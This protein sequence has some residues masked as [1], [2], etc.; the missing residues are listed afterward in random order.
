MNYNFRAH[1]QAVVDKC[2]KQYGTKEDAIFVLDAIVADLRMQV[3]G[4]DEIIQDLSKHQDGEIT[5]DN[6]TKTKTG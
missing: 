1:K 2:T 6:D 4:K 5:I 3:E